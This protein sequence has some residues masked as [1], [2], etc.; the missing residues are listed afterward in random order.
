MRLTIAVPQAHIDNANHFAM[1]LGYSEAD[2]LT[3]R[4]PSWQD[5]QGNLYALA[6]LPVS[7]LFVGAATSPLVR[8]EWDTE[9]VIDMAKASQAQALV[10]IWMPS[11]ETP[12]APQANPSQ[13]VAIL[14]MDGSGAIK[15]MGLTAVPQDEDWP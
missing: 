15:A 2:G 14:G 7:D 8:P 11:E 4:N 10:L 1:V 6:S 9:E 5:A 3:Y 12:D 13:I